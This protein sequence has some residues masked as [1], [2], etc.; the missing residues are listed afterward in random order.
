VFTSD[1]NFVEDQRDKSNNRASIVSGEEG[2]LFQELKE[3]FQVVDPFPRNNKISFSW[4]SR[5]RDGSRI[6][7]H[8]DRF[9]MYTTADANAAGS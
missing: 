3:T 9:Y 4:D 7:A 2:R 1:W 8:L 6:L 5:R